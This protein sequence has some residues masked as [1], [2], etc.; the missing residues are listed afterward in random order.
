MN[1]SQLLLCHYGSHL[2]PGNCTVLAC[3]VLGE[4]TR[5]CRTMPLEETPALGQQQR[6][7]EVLQKRESTPS[8]VST[9]PCTKQVFPLHSN[10]N[11]LFYFDRSS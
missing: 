4:Q 3:F 10:H 11:N 8:K 5:V 2:G 1:V 7:V 6:N 9:L